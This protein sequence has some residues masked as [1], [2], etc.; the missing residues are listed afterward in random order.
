MASVRTT[1]SGRR[2]RW[3]SSPNFKG[4]VNM[5]KKEG[6]VAMACSSEIL[7][8]NRA[9]E[10]CFSIRTPRMT[11]GNWLTRST[12]VRALGGATARPTGSAITLFTSKMLSIFAWNLSKDSSSRTKRKERRMQ[13][14]AVPR[15]KMLIRVFSLF[16]RRLRKVTIKKFLYMSLSCLRENEV[17]GFD[18]A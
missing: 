10:F 4:K 5:S 14:M 18:Q 8:F 6:S 12:E 13:A 3:S 16:F 2:R 11:S 15:P 9:I 17:L 7:S 1:E